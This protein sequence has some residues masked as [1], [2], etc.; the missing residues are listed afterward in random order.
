MLPM[1]T[2]Y[3]SDS[4]T[5]THMLANADADDAEAANA[6]LILRVVLGRIQF[7]FSFRISLNVGFQGLKGFGMCR[8]PPGITLG[9]VTLCACAKA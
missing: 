6:V 5:V 7:G 3:D 1:H 2:L 4:Y 8:C 9:I